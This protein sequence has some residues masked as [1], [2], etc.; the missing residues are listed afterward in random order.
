[1]FVALA[2]ILEQQL[3]FAWK[4]L[5]KRNKKIMH[6][7]DVFPIIVVKSNYNISNYL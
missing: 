7:Q 3:K 5:E 4:V 1:M 6:I 2:K